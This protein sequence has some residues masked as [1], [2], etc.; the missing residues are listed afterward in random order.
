MTKKE[1]LELIKENSR[2]KY[3]ICEL[4]K[5]IP[6]KREYRQLKRYLEE[7]LHI[8][9]EQNFA[10]KYFEKFGKESEE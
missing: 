5:N 7:I 8:E 2:L 4:V 1:Q 9:K 3:C 6:D 10:E